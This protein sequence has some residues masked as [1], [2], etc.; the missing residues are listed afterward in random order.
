M[1]AAGNGIGDGELEMMSGIAFVN[2]GI[3]ESNP[4]MLSE[5]IVVVHRRDIVIAD[6]VRIFRRRR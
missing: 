6:L 1:D 3:F 2:R 4:V 5:Q